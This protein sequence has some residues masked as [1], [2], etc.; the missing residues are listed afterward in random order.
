MNPFGGNPGPTQRTNQRMNARIKQ[1]LANGGRVEVSLVR[2]AA[3]DLD[4]HAIENRLAR[5]SQRLLLENLALIAAEAEGID[6]S[7]TY[8]R[9]LLT[10]REVS[11]VAEQHTSTTSRSKS[12]E[13]RESASSRL[14]PLANLR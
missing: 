13:R 2:G 12:D 1:H 3:I 8:D 10:T 9:R 4:G 7:R 14:E 6:L 5:S 11:D